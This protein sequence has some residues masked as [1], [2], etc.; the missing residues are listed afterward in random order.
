MNTERRRW[1]RLSFPVPTFVHWTDDQGREQMEFATATN[2]SA[3]GALIL[4]R[5]QVVMGS[6]I[7]LEFPR[8]Q[9]SNSRPM[10]EVNRM[11]AKAVRITA[12]E[13]AL[14]IGVEFSEPIVQATGASKL[15]Q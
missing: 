3:G 15:A 2:I 13:H 5:N 9:A 4:M 6:I 10:W 11:F 8:S 14:Y 12:G 1:E 7:R